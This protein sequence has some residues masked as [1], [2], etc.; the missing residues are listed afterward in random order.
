MKKFKEGEIFRNVIKAYPKVQFF[1]NNGLVRFDRQNYPAAESNIPI[2][3][4][5]LFDLIHTVY[6][7]PTAGGEAGIDNGLLTEAGDFLIT[8]SGDNIIIES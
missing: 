2:E 5:G 3:S 4:I 7:G 1:A 6:A 8:E